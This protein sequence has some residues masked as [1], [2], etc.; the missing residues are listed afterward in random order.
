MEEQ[1]EYSVFDEVDRRSSIEFANPDQRFINCTVD[2]A[3]L[4]VFFFIASVVTGNL[5]RL[6][7]V[8]DGE[9]NETTMSKIFLCVFI[10]SMTLIFYTLVEGFSKG[11]SIGKLITRTRAVQDDLVSLITFSQA[12][13]RS[14]CRTIPFEVFSGFGGTPWHDLLTKTKVVKI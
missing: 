5:M 2:L 13:T 8:S 12:F 11:R 6:Y 14:L 10:Y 9:L 3:A 1:K 4:Y 7:G